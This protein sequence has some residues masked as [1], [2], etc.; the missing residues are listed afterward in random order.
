MGKWIECTA[1]RKRY[2]SGYKYINVNIF[3]HKGNANPNYA[4][5]PPHTGQ[6]ANHHH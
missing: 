2:T 4:V 3:S 5:I 6:T 1:L